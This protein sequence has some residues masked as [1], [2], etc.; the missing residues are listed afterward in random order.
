MH[1]EYESREK[2]LDLI[3]LDSDRVFVFMLSDN[4]NR[5]K[6]LAPALNDKYRF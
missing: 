4:F 2:G 5:L 1:P 6:K 3:Y